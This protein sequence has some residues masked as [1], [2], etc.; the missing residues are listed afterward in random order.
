MHWAWAILPRWCWGN[1]AVLKKGADTCPNTLTLGFE[2]LLVLSAARQAAQSALSSEQFIKID[3]A[4]TATATKAAQGSQFCN[5][6]AKRK[7]VLLDAV[8]RA[9]QRLITARVLKI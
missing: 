1:G 3:T 8:K 7:N 5:K 9:G 6:T 4:A 2:E